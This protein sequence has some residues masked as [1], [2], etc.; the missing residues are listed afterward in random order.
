M[1]KTEIRNILPSSA[2]NT[3][4]A[5]VLGDGLLVNGH[6]LKGASFLKRFERVR[7]NTLEDGITAKVAG[8]VDE[9]GGL[10]NLIGDRVDSLALV[11][12]ASERA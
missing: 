8:Q 6:L 3:R 7:L 10:L 2:G 4:H 5:V 12:S 11:E 1:R 9:M